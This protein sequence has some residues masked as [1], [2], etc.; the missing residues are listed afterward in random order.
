MACSHLLLLAAVMAS[1]WATIP[2]PAQYFTSQLV[3]HFS[4]PT[5][6]PATY[7]QRYY[8]IDEHFGSPPATLNQ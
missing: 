1:A 4:A 8:S 6:P 7:S 2:R 3:D 5:N